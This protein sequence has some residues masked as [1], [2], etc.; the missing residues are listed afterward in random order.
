MAADSELF[1]GLMSGTSVDG[2]DVALVSFRG[3]QV[4]LKGQYL[5]PID[6]STKQQIISISTPEQ[7]SD[8]FDQVEALAELDVELGRL[9]AKATKQLLKQKNLTAND[10][11]A[12]GSHG[13]T[14]RH[15]PNRAA[16]FSIQIGDPNIIAELTGIDTI[17]DFRRMDIA[18]GGQGAPLVPAFH[19][20]LFRNKKQSRVIL[21]LGG[22]ANITI[23]HKDTDQSVVGYDTGP[24]NTLLDNYFCRQFPDSHLDFDKDSLF[25]KTGQTNQALLATL[26]S[27]EYFNQSLP[28]STG[29]EYFSLNWL[30][31]SL[32]QLTEKI[33]P[34]DIQRTLLELTVISIKDAINAQNI[35]NYQVYACGGGMHNSFLLERLSDELSTIILTTNAVGIDGDYLEAMTF[36]W[37]ARQRILE[38]PGN[39]PS[40]TGASKAKVL[41]SVYLA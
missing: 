38:L 40:V 15:R 28:K 4:E 1:I 18:A 9:F 25:A 11:R 26:L 35:D 32:A 17:A 22:I 34:E 2:I 16:P 13:Q 5:Y 3:N 8:G 39:L 21:N 10:I 6:D 27:D 33:L 14:I 37:L 36:A 19:D 24:A 30:D 41:G 23:L 7:Q 29:R 20:S 31:K 12:V